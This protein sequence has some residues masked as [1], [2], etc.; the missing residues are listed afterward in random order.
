M[1]LL[2]KY[3]VLNNLIVPDVGIEKK[4]WRLSDLMCMG[5]YYG[6]NYKWI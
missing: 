2:V 5:Q 6:I 1:T 3:V 4:K